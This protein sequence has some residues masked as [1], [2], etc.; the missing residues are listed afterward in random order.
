MKGL[1]DD[2]L[3][4]HL[5]HD[6]VSYLTYTVGAC[7]IGCESTGR[8]SCTRSNGRVSVSFPKK[9][10]SL[11]SHE[12]ADTGNKVPYTRSDDVRQQLSYHNTGPTLSST[13]EEVQAR[14]GRGLGPKSEY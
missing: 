6:D 7:R 1:T 9:G 11:L 4:L 3:R 2:S 8:A 12:E 10:T 14:H 13:E 5:C